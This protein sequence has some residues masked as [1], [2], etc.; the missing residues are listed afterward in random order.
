[1]LAR[2]VISAGETVPAAADDDDVVMIARYSLRA[3][4]SC[5]R[6]VGLERI[7]EQSQ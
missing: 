4:K 1:V 7:F 6:V 3:E 5:F 2:E